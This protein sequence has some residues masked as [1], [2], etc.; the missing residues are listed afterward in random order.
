[1][2]SVTPNEEPKPPHCA[3]GREHVAVTRRGGRRKYTFTDH[4]DQL[5]RE[6]YLSRRHSK[7]LPG[8]RL[9]AKKVGIA[10]WALKRRACELGL[11][12][13]KERLWSETELQ[14]LARYAWMGD[15]RRA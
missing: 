3:S 11:A 2:E 14:I 5:I 1:M 4:I 13:T 8:I 12:R 7:Q 9:L 15:E 6:C 10:H